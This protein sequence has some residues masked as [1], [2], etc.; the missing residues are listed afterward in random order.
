MMVLHMQNLNCC[1][2][3][4]EMTGMQDMLLVFCCAETAV[5]CDH[6][7]CHLLSYCNQSR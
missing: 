1:H 4:T 2:I 6:Y 3:Y 5:R 7:C